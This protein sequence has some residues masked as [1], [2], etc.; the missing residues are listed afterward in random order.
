M[1]RTSIQDVQS[2]PDPLFSMNWDLVLPRIPGTA[3][4]RPFTFKCQTSSIPGALLESVP[5]NLH[6]IELRFAGR[7][8]YTHSFSVTVMETRDMS[9]RDIFVNWGN[10]ARSWLDNSGSHKSVYAVPGELILYDDTPK[11]VRKITLFG[12]WPESISDAQLDGQTSA[13]VT[14]DVQFSFDYTVDS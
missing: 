2:L 5:V 4:T 7:K 11:E 8:N 9:S 14:Y 3:D 10:I 1:S 12:L 13:V 6:G